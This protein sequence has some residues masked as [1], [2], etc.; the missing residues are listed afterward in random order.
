MSYSFA[1]NNG[2]SPS[3]TTKF[4]K[5]QIGGNNREYTTY[6]E[7]NWYSSA[8]YD[9]K[10]LIVSDTYSQG[11]STEG[12]ATPTFWRSAEN[13]LD[14]LKDL[15]NQLPDVN[16]VTGFTDVND[17]INY[18]N[19]SDKYLISQESDSYPEGEIVTSGLVFNLDAGYSNSYPKSGTTWYDVSDNTIN[20]SFINGTSYGS[21]NGGT[22]VFDGADD[23]INCGN[24]PALQFTTSGLTVEYF[25]KT[26]TYANQNNKHYPC[27]LSK[28]FHW[29]AAD[30]IF[31]S[32]I[33][34]DNNGGRVG[35]NITTQNGGVGV[36]SDNPI[37]TN[38]WIHFVASYNGSDVRLYIN[39]V[40]QSTIRTLTGSLIYLDTPLYI[41]VARFS[42]G[43]NLNGYRYQGEIPIV[44]IYDRGLTADEV[45]QNFNAQKG[46]FGL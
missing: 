16:G 46:R 37:T 21:N 32:F 2:S 27:V 8:P 36:Y 38:N 17:A 11:W 5:L 10:F 29:T 1:Y 43:L 30:S 33:N 15:V 45:Q 19:S 41:G 12:N 9:G 42:G 22:I 7:L 23:Y 20:T 25:T 34:N 4:A 14:S 35:I 31:S 28:R 24:P 44:R 39:N 40:L 6:G 26:P 3:G 13:S 18:I